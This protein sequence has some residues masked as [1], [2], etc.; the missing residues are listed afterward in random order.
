MGKRKHISLV[1]LFNYHSD[2]TCLQSKSSACSERLKSD[3]KEL[4]S[5][6]SYLGIEIVKIFEI[7]ILKTL[8]Q[9]STL[10]PQSVPK[11]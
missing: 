7:V 11:P 10:V 2:V 6:L 5:G 3:N 4:I 1:A 8:M 9:S